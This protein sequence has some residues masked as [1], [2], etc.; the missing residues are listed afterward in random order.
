VSTPTPLAIIPPEGAA[1]LPK[2][3]LKGIEEG[4]LQIQPSVVFAALLD[5]DD[6]DE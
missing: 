2:H 3:V 6:L 5:K 1:H 4:F